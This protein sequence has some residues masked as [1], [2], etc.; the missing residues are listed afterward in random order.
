MIGFITA[1]HAPP[2][3]DPAVSTGP[4]RS[5]VGDKYRAD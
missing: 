5:L 1:D 2:A 4:L 3:A